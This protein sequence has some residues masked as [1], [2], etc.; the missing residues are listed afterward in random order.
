MFISHFGISIA[1]Y[2]S[3]VSEN[4]ELFVYVAGRYNDRVLVNE[5]NF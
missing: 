2:A 3:K 4:E 1:G 5:N